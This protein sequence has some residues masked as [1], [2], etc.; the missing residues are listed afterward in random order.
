MSNLL[1]REET[2]KY[3]KLLELLPVDDPKIPKIHQLLKLDKIER[4]KEILQYK[5]G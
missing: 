5:R 4:S 3:I 2:Q 1:T